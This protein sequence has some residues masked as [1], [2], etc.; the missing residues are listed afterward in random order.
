MTTTLVLPAEIAREIDGA[1]WQSVESAAVL[2]ARIA[3][4]PDGDI[5]ILGRALRWVRDNAYVRRE[6]D[7]LTIA[8]E[9]YVSMLSEAETRG[10]T[11]I[12]LHTHPGEDA[13]PRHSPHDAIVDEELSEAF[14][15]RS[16]SDYYGALIFSPRRPKPVFTGYV[17]RR[18]EPQIPIDRLWCV[19][20]RWHL[21]HSFDSGRPVLPEIFDRNVRA[22]GHAVQETLANL[23]V[24]IAGC[25][26]VGSA[27][28]EQ[29]IRLGVRHFLL[30]DPDVLSASNLTRVYGSTP[31]QVGSPKVRVLAEHLTRIA[32]EV[33]C[34]TITSMVTVE[35]T[36]RR[37]TASDVIFGCTD[38]NAGRLVLS[39]LATFFLTPVID[40][41]VLLS[42]DPSGELTGIDGRVTT[43][44][45]GHACLLCRGRIDMPRA[46]AE[47]LTP[48]ERRRRADE[49][50]APALERT[51]PA[52]VA[53]TTF[54]AAAAVGEL[55]ERLIGYGQTPRP[56]EV[57]LRC[58]DREIST[59]VAFP[60]EG[61][62][63]H[64]SSDKLGVGVTEPFLE[65]IW[66]T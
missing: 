55:L 27:V 49:G 37:L 45:P 22:F 25:G 23:K 50:Y 64:P 54:V 13:V 11:C 32:P 16:G 28:A 31:R 12:W 21:L 26:G 40:C 58:H 5:R 61:H 34:G 33:E 19:G 9:G 4:T 14:R 30:V 3:K 10:D 63:C 56:S 7:G 52:V 35:S 8:S 2:L 48:G 41:G 66:P 6:V 42:S 43:L 17:Q 47:L 59:N 18:G 36:A 39:R 15:I 51:E 24:A 1:T 29:L 62:Y 46:A 20:D 60:R 38:D 53:Y 57:I 65:Q 44:I